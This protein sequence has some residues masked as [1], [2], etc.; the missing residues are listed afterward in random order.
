MRKNLLSLVLILFFGVTQAQPC[1]ENTHSLNFNGSSSITLNSNTNLQLIET[2]ITVEAWIYPTSWAFD[3]ANGTI[4]CHH[5]WTSGAEM[6]FVLRAGGTG[7]L[8]FNIGGM[9]PLGVA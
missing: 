8:S 9:D 1:I 6:G 2:A 7:Q 4:V 5:S 3:P